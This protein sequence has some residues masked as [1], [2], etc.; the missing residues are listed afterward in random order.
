MG[1]RDNVGMILWEELHGQYGNFETIG[2]IHKCE[3][4][5]GYR[6]ISIGMIESEQCYKDRLVVVTL[7]IVTYMNTKGCLFLGCEFFFL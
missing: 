4:V 1:L 3:H 6:G 2:K 7:V 5:T